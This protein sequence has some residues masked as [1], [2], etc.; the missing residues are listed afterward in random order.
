MDNEAGVRLAAI[1]FT[2]EDGIDG[3]LE[4]VVRTLQ[5]RGVGVSGYLQ[6]ETEDT[7]A[8]CNITHLEDVAS[9]TWHRIS[10]ALGS[11]SRGCRLDPGALADVSGLLLARLEAGTEFVVLNRFGKGE[12]EGQGFRAIIERAF[13][14]RIP[15]L[16]AVRQTYEP[17]WLSFTDGSARLL[18]A[19]RTAIL[20]W[21]NDAIAEDARFDRTVA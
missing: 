5:S 15:V 3:L 12:S 19:E 10:Q 13:A 11:G 6:R 20:T 14:L 2:P 9:G 1:R 18:P 7:A 4:A 17:A 16:T 21:A 8:C